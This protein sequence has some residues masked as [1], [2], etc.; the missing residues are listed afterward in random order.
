M[1]TVKC[2]VGAD[3]LNM[4]IISLLSLFTMVFSFLSH[5]TGT[6]YLPAAAWH[7][8]WL[9][10]LQAIQEWRC[11]TRMLQCCVHKM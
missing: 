11:T 2:D 10:G 8:W 3:L 9:N 1:S 5:S 7:S 6:V 4:R